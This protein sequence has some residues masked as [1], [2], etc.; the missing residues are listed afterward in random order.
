M[1]HYVKILLMLLTFCLT[2]T[3]FLACGTPA[4][5]ETEAQPGESDSETETEAVGCQHTNSTAGKS[6]E[7]TCAEAGYTQY[8]CQDCGEV[9]KVEK[10]LAD[11]Q[12]VKTVKKGSS[13]EM[14]TCEACGQMSILLAPSEEMSFDAY[15]GGDAVIEFTVTGGDAKVEFFMDGLS[16]SNKNYEEGAHTATVF[17]GMPKD[18]YTLGVK[19]NGSGRVEITGIVI[20]GHINTRGGVIL[21][22]NKKHDNNGTY[23]DFFVYVRTSDPS[24][25][26][27]IRYNFIHEYN[28]DVV[29]KSNSTANIDAFRVKQA[30]LVEITEKTATDLKYTKLADVLQQG[31]ISLA[32]KEEGASDFVGGYHGDDHMTEFTLCADGREY[33][34]GKE[35]R[36]VE[37]SYL[38]IHQKATIN[39]CAKP[40]VPVMIHDQHYTIDS[41]GVK[42]DKS[43]EWLVDDFAVSLGYLQMFTVYRTACEDLMVLDGEG[44]NP[45]PT[46]GANILEDTDVKVEEQNATYA[47]KRV[48]SNAKNRVL[49][50]SSDKT[51]ISAEIGFEILNDSCK[52]SSAAVQLR[53]KDAKDNKWYVSFGDKGGKKTPSTGDLW[54]LATYFDIDYVAPAN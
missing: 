8:T 35:D 49:K 15:C 45:F 24:G 48:L 17:K 18:E 2:A 37:C 50:Y 44:K 34:P 22:L 10:P 30:F 32:V 51:G 23:E 21:E 42:N 38:T 36:V 19:N 5:T 6:T 40:D 1:K 11:H 3:L 13:L 7:S 28:T 29:D 27:Y 26:Y 41:T 4:D 52:V 25:K 53:Y 46:A 31:E 43:V 33:V 16:M 39:R 54:E 14:E 20:D 9:Y 47:D 12:F